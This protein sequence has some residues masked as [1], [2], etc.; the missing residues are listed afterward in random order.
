MRLV[1]PP[2][3]R[4][5]LALELLLAAL[6]G[7]A[8]SLPFVHTEFWWLQLLIVAAL[9]RRAA[10]A[11]P[12]RAAAL[13]LVFGTAWMASGT[14]WLF[15]SLHTYGGLPTWLAV[16][17]IAALSAFVSLF[18]STAMMAFARW[19]GGIGWRDAL[20]F[21]VLWLLAELARGVIFTGFPWI[22]SGYAQIDSPLAALAPWV[23]VYGIGFVVAVLA[24]WP[25][26]NGR[27]RAR[28]AAVPLL[29]LGVVLLAMAL[30]GPGQ[31]SR[32]SGAPLPT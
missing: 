29:T 11:T 17:A 10:A 5:P 25:A 22:A 8:H 27:R 26:L 28:S 6:L 18:L 21:G 23:G 15:I 13:G 24:S 20:L 12:R 19:R 30:A 32:P 4:W 3:P 7:A 1:G 31:F 14:W 16:L 2:S 9:A